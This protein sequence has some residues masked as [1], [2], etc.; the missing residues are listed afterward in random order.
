MHKRIRL[1]KASINKWN[2]NRGVFNWS[3][4]RVVGIPNLVKVAEEVLPEISLT[5]DAETMKF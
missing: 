1:I 5:R 3:K 2:L 4:G